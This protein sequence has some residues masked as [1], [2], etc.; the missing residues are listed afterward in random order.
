MNESA[1]GGERKAAGQLNET[2]FLLFDMF[3]P[4]L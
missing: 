2:A 1:G 4:E 3:Q